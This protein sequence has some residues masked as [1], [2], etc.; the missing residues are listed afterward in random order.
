M[1]LSENKFLTISYLNIR[2]QTGFHLEKQSQIEEF[3]RYSQSDIWHIQEAHVG[4][5]T[6]RECNYIENNYSVISNKATN[7]YG[8]ASLIKNDLQVENIKCDT[9]GR[10]ILFEISG[11]TSQIPPKI[12][13]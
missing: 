5:D 1:C 12:P 6:F 11:V 4:E 8:T 13:L 9:G 2:G 7:K 3:L 10:V